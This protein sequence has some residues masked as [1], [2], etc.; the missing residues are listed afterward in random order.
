MHIH[1]EDSK[2][3]TDVAPLHAEALDQSPFDWQGSKVRLEESHE[4][5]KRR[6]GDTS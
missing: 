2:L 6:R 3:N 4:A 5:L 1:A